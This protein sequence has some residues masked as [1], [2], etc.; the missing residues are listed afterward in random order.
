M[1]SRYQHVEYICVES[2]SSKG[3]VEYLSK[4]KHF[5]IKGGPY[6]KAA[7]FGFMLVLSTCTQHTYKI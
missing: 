4:K 6:K 5:Q 3:N 2:F 1:M 7:I